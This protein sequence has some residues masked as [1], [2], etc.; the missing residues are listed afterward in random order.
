[1]EGMDFSYQRRLDDDVIVRDGPKKRL[2][3]CVPHHKYGYAC[4]LREAITHGDLNRYGVTYVKVRSWYPRF[5]DRTII[6]WHLGTSAR[7]IRGRRN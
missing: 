2:Y 7:I 5:L 1:M 3:L 4:Y 6:E